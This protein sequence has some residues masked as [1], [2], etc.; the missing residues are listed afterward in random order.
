MDTQAIVSFFSWREPKVS[1][2][3]LILLIEEKVFWFQI[4]VYYASSVMQVLN[5]TQ[6]L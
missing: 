4:S 6:K 3:E 1:Y 5:S 2:F